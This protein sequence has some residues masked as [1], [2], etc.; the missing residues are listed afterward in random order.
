MDDGD[1]V[2]RYVLEG[3]DDMHKLIIM[4]AHACGGS[5]VEGNVKLQKLVFMLSDIDDNAEAMGFYPDMYGP[6]SDIVAGEVRYLSDLGILSIDGNKTGITD[7]GKS[8]AEQLAEED[9]DMFSTIAEY[10][11]MFNDMSTNEVLTYVYLLY[12]SMATHS[13]V[14]D[15]LEPDMEKHVMSMLRKRKISSGKAATL[16][17]KSRLYVIEEAVKNGISVLG[18]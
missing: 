9:S 7:A 17:G 1:E 4:L 8:I 15:K 13:V 16:L 2:R 11:E 18:Y 5:P 3:D 14:R 10:K 12:P 6:Y